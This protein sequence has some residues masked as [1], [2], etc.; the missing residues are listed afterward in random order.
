VIFLS[1]NRTLRILM[2]SCKS[3][4]GT[5]WRNSYAQHE[6]CSA[7][8]KVMAFTGLWSPRSLDLPKPGNF[9]WGCN[10]DNAHRNN[11][12][13]LDELETKIP[14]SIAEILPIALQAVSRNILRHARVCN[15]LVHTLEDF[16]TRCMSIVNALLRINFSSKNHH[17]AHGVLA[18]WRQPSNRW[19]Y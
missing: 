18:E 3:G 13:I 16:V 19:R 15:I 6:V 10:K 7:S 12:Y 1:E 17:T 14:N 2:T 8:S 11:P 4:L 9:L 5:F